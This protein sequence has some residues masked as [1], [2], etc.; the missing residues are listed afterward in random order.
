MSNYADNY[1]TALN[2]Y[3]LNAQAHQ[4]HDQQ[5]MLYQGLTPA[6]WHQLIGGQ[7][8]YQQSTQTIAPAE[9][10]SSASES[11]SWLRRRVAEMEWRG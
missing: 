7:G 8:F 2:V 1:A 3:G 11:V 5:T 10:P 6:S 4:L 9:V